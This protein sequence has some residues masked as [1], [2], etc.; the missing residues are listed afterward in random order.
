VRLHVKWAEDDI[1]EDPGH[2]FNRIRL[3]DGTVVD[4][5]A[6]DQGQL[7]RYRIVTPDLVDLLRL[8]DYRRRGS[9]ISR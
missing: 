2:V 6:A 3:K 1:A 8:I 7:I 4:Y 9:A 5:S